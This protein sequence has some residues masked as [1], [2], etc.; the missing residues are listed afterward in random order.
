[1]VRKVIYIDVGNMTMKEATYLVATLEGK[2]QVKRN[3]FIDFCAILFS[4]YIPIF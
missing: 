4:F 2:K 1:M 3:W